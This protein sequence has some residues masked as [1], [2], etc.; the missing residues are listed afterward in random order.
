MTGLSPGAELLR[1]AQYKGFAGDATL[2]Y[3]FE[4]ADTMWIN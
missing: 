2:A 4:T 1:R 3:G